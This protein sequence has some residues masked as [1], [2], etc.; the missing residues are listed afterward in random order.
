MAAP[1]IA[2][3]V[4]IKKGES[5]HGDFVVRDRT[6]SAKHE[7]SLKKSSGLFDFTQ[8]LVAFRPANKNVRI[9]LWQLFFLLFE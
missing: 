1:P 5:I 7:I 9:K 4:V 8:L 2:D 6:A 3:I